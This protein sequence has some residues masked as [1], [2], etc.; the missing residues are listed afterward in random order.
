MTFTPA[1]CAIMLKNTH[2]EVKK[3]SILNNFLDGFNSKFNILEGKYTRFVTR[4]VN[5]RVVTFLTLIVFSIGTWVL[6][7]SVPAGFI[8]N[9]DQ[10]LFYAIIQTPAGSTL[11]RT[12]QIALELQKINL[13]LHLE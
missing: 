9:E 3:K 13:D 10:G 12:D 4:I 7:S 2:S 6:S 8:P 11:E 1:I 5:R